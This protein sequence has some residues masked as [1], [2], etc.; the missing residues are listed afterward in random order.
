MYRF[1]SI[2]CFV[3]LMQYST[4]AQE[5]NA[6]VTLQTSKV[7]NQVDTQFGNRFCIMVDASPVQFS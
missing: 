2:F 5:L 1:L 4:V 6:T 3:V 7:E